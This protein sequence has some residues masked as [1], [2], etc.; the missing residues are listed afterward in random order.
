MSTTE[1]LLVA[2]LL[3]G[4][5]LSG[6]IPFSYLVARAR[7]VDLRQVGSGNVG[8]ANVWRACGFGP[9]VVAAALDILKGY[10]PTLVGC[11]YFRSA[12]SGVAG[13]HRRDPGSHVSDL[14]E[15]QGRQS[16]GY[17]H[18]RTAGDHA[19]VGAVRHR[20]VG[21]GIRDHAHSSVASL[22]A[23]AVEIIAGTVFI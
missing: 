4:A 1:L 3:V 11:G 19:A 7:G 13:G 9:F 8:G 6:S 23:A 5:Y 15:L 16:R 21:A 2:A 17:Q 22:T 20:R 10:L 18:R 14:S 12:D